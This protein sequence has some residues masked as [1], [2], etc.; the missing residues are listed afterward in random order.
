MLRL[1]PRPSSRC[2]AIVLLIGFQ[3]VHVRQVFSQQVPAQQTESKPEVRPITDDGQPAKEKKPEPKQNGSSDDAAK[4]TVQESEDSKTSEN[5]KPNDD[6]TPA[7][8]KPKKAAPIKVG[9]AFI[10]PPKNDPNFQLMGE[11][12]GELVD[13]SSEGKK[14]FMGLQLRPLAGDRFQAIVYG[15]GL[16]G[17]EE[18]GGKKFKLI[19]MRSDETLVLSGGPWAVFVS[20][21]GCTLINAKGEMLGQLKRIK[22]ISPT[23]GAKPPEGATVLFDGSDVEQFVNGQISERGLLQ[24]GALI[25]PMFQDFDLHLEF[26]LPYMPD[27]DGQKRGNSG[28]YLQSRYECQILDSFGTDRVFDGLGALYRLKKPDLNMAF[29]PLVWQTYD[30]RFTAPRWAASGKKIRNAHITSWVNGVKVQDDVSLPT[31]TGNGQ[32]ESPTL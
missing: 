18:F 29:P 17:D 24:Q 28:L 26:R 21:E 20:P 31:K 16:P 5:Q 14:Q 7:E 6:Q 22:R 11:F 3:L 2:I 4:S 23:L 19:G 8:P 30:V 13:P 1:S 27:A 15:G 12:V 10:A 9:D 25:S 32:Q